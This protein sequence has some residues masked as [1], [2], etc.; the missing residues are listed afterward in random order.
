MARYLRTNTATRVTVGPFLDKTDGITPE[1]ALTATNE[2]L[3]LVVDTGGVPTLALD[4][5]ATASAGDNDMVHITGDDAGLYDLELT[6]AQLNYVGRAILSVN[7]VTD[8]LPVWHE[9][10]ILPAVIYDAMVLGTDLFD[11]SMTQILGTA[12]STPATAGILDVNIKNIVNAAVNTALAQLGVNVVSQ[13]NIDFGALQKTSLN[14]ATPASVQGAVG[15]VTGAVGSVTG[16]VGSV[17]AGVTVTTNND[18]TG[19]ALSAAGVQAIWDAL[20]SAL[21]T[22]GSIGKK[23]ADWVVGTIDTYTGNTKQTGDAFARLGAPAGASVSADVAAVKADSAAILL[24]TGTDGVVLPQAQ[25]DKVW[26]T[27]ARALTDKADFA[28]SSASRDAIWDQA[29][30]LSISFE[31]LLQRLYQVAANNKMTVNES[32]G[33][34]AVRNIGD[35][36]NIATGSVVSSSGTTTRAELAYV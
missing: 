32:S 13:A 24:D 25:A 33:A 8:H 35:T 21:T 16:A 23:L 14:A 18:K 29:G 6:A 28:L 11:V 34:V 1:V 7:Y 12:V 30:T 19:Y 3:T 36:L 5:N 9:F 20:T 31:N 17:T 10:I 22:V 15:S 26:S 4:A 27:V 2:H